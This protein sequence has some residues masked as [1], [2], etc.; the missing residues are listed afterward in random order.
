MIIIAYSSGRVFF[1]HD[2][3]KRNE[4]CIRIGEQTTVMST[5]QIRFKLLNKLSNAARMAIYAG[6]IRD[7]VKRYFN[8]I[9]LII[10]P[11]YTCNV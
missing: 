11:N 4:K 1:I 9:W 3:K 7:D 6:N 10:P 5:R 8:G 2:V